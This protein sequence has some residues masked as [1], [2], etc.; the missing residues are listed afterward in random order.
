LNF[1]CAKRAFFHLYNF[2]QEEPLSYQPRKYLFL[3]TGIYYK[4]EEDDYQVNSVI[5]EGISSLF[6]GGV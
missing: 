1:L 4:A 3:F 6:E 5:R 2:A